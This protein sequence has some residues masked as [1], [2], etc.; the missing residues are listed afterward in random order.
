MASSKDTQGRQ[1]ISKSKSSAGLSRKEFLFSAAGLVTMVGGLGRNGFTNFVSAK[2]LNG[3]RMAILYDSSKCIGCKM[4]EK[5]CVKENNLLSTEIQPGELSKTCWTTIKSTKNDKGKNLLLKRQCMHCTDAS[6]TAVCP[7]GAAAHHG[8]YVEI[9]QDVCIGCGYCEE[10]C[11]FGVPHKDPPKGTAQKCTFCIERIKSGLE[12]ICTEA[13]PIGASTFGVREDLL[14][15]ANKKV[16]YLAKAGWPE[17]QLYGENELGGLGVI[18]ILLKS[19]VFYGLPE[20]PKQATKNVLTQWVS[21]I[22]PAAGLLVPFWYLF[23]RIP[24]KNKQSAKLKE[25]SK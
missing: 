3:T 22:I 10:A 8:E 4:C 5:A 17:A 18:Y 15:A 6:C 1:K 2:P 12:P 20:K 14:A 11:P 24:E 25:G 19:P 13:C 7:T 23:K 9:D 21:G 16:K